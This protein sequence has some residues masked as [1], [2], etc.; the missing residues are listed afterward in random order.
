MT[1]G[2]RAADHSPWYLLIFGGSGTRFIPMDSAFERVSMWTLGAFMR[3]AHCDLEEISREQEAA[4][5][6]VGD[7]F[8]RSLTS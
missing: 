5:R 3:T 8:I 1:W 2:Y 7:S 6:G 4:N